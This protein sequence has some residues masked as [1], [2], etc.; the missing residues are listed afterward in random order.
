MSMLSEASKQIL[1][2]TRATAQK[3]LSNIEEEMQNCVRAIQGH[4]DSIDCIEKNIEYLE[5]QS[6]ILLNR[7][8]ELTSEIGDV[9]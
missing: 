9:L 2:S 1:K 8:H 5:E 6:E 3:R 4:R 7:I